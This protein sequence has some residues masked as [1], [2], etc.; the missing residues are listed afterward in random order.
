[1]TLVA[2]GVF[3]IGSLGAAFAPDVLTLV[4]ARF[5]IGLGVG[6]TSVVVPMYLSEISPTRIRGTLS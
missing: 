4:A 1:M 5:V 6:L 2:A 3:A